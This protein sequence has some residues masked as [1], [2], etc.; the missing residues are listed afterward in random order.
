LTTEV[1]IPKHIKNTETID[2]SHNY[3]RGQKFH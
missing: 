2:F 1:F 3:Q